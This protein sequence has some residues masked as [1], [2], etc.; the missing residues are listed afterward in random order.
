MPGRFGRLAVAVSVGWILATA[1]AVSPA[2]AQLDPAVRDRVVAA[3]VAVAIIVDVT[4]ET[5]TES[6][7]VP[8]GSGTVVSADGLILTNRHVVDM[9]A[10]RL[11]LDQWE[12][13]ARADGNRLA[14][15]L[16]EDRV[17]ILG[18]DGGGPPE[19][20]YT[21]VIA[22]EDDAL[23]LAV[24][25][26]VADQ[27]G[28]PLDPAR[29]NL[30]YLPLGDSDAVQLGDPIDVFGYPANGGDSLTYTTG[31]VSGFNFEEGVAG[32]A[33]ITT[34]AT[35]SGGSSG[36]TAVDRRGR[37]IGIPTRGSALYCRP[38]DTNGDGEV[39]ADDV[40]C[41]P[42]GGSIGQVRPINLARA[43]LRQVR[44]TPA[45]DSATTSAPTPTRSA[46][47]VQ[48]TASS[49]DETPAQQAALADLLPTEDEA[50]QGLT[51][52]EDATRTE[53]E[54]ARSLGTADA[55]QRLDDWGWTS[56]A[57]RR[58]SGT[59]MSAGST[60]FL[61]V[62]IHRFAS[63]EGAAEALTY[64]SNQV[65]S[66]QGLDE[67]PVVPLGDA[68]RAVIGT[69]DDGTANVVVYV[70][71]GEDVIRVGGSSAD[72]DPMDDVVNIAN[73]IVAKEEE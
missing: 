41:V 39:N 72:G 54:V 21:A 31:V 8:V 38:G 35:L 63:A 66:A 51:M 68:V 40:G 20:T 69:S 25:R 29:L 13:Q 58:F 23:D 24:L 37:L 17:L 15:D 11:Q 27:D 1:I 42:V 9:T 67:V 62:S 64:F 34:D 71:H 49:D 36:G 43:I 48:E 59:H 70:Q 4:E 33:W 6:I 50:P 28:R 12:T 60:T 16:N 44:S 30:P 46:P 19:P 7:P 45:V 47:M 73:A 61:D 65:M 55:A 56:N 5:R 10:H 2:Q 18:S 32:H 26:V 53:D 22:A 52:T 3:A 57:Y 14:F